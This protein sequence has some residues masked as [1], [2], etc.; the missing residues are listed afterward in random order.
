MGPLWRGAA[1]DP[2]PVVSRQGGR[3]HARQPGGQLQRRAVGGIPGVRHR[4]FTNFAADSEGIDVDDIIA[5]VLK[6]V[7][8]PGEKDYQK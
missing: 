6:E 1:C 3:G 2:I 5:K 7:Q 4:M 8:E